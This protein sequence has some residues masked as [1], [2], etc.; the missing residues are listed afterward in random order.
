MD[1]KSL[2][3]GFLTGVLLTVVISY[4][5]NLNGRYTVVTGERHSVYILDTRT[6]TCQPFVGVKS[7]KSLSF[8]T[9]D[10]E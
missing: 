2:I 3:V 10:K 8:D 6:G 1:T 9:K 7:T 5:V 4:F